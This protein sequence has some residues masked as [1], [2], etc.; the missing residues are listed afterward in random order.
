[1]STLTDGPINLSIKSSDSIVVCTM[2]DKVLVAELEK[3]IKE[4]V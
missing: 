4:A 1:M 2:F 3:R